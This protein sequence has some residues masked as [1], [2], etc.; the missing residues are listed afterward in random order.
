MFVP[1]YILTRGNLSDK[2]QGCP[3]PLLKNDTLRFYKTNRGGSSR[4]SK[5]QKMFIHRYDDYN[6]DIKYLEPNE[7]LWIVQDMVIIRFF[8]DIKYSSFQ[9]HIYGVCHVR[10]TTTQ[11]IYMRINF[12]N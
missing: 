6:I 5:S 1:G 8:G 7:F 3:F 4:C 11:D 12:F 2:R 9:I 10:G